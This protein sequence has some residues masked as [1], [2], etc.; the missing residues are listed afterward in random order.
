MMIGLA[1][2]EQTQMIIVG[3]S[4]F[5]DLKY[6]QSSCLARLVKMHQN[7]GN[8]IHSIPYFLGKDSPP[9]WCHL[10]STAN[11]CVYKQELQNVQLQYRDLILDRD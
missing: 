7:T 8:Y 9:I 3:A 10:I 4:Q 2:S 5:I 1:Y 6:Q 11:L